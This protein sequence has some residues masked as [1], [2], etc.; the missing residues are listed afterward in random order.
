MGFHFERLATVAW[1]LSIV[2][3]LAFGGACRQGVP[4]VDVAPK[5]VVADGTLSGTVRGPEGTSPVSGRT[6]EAVNVES[7]ERYRVTTGNTGGFTF[8]VQPGKYRLELTLK[9]GEIIVKQPGVIEVG[10][11]DIDA[12]ADFVLG[13]SGLY[14]PHYPSPRGDDGLGSAIA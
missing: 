7:G 12:H 1:L 6:V 2:A 9:Q 14:R 3:G 4:V 11:A 5:P 10:R 13:S 8:K